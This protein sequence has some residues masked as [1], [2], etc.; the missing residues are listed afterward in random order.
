MAE[1]DYAYLADYAQIEGGKISAL[2]ASYT[3][4]RVAEVPSGWMTTVVGRIRAREDEGPINLSIKIVPPNGEYDME[5]AGAIEAGKDVRPYDG[6]VGLLFTFMAQMPILSEGLYQV[7]V[8]VEGEQVRR[9]AFDV[10]I[11]PS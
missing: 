7:L 9:L 2:G 4:A 11:V 1:L 5:V 8:F 10:E 3:H 6:K